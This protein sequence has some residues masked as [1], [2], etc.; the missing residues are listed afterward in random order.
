M[1]KRMA[2]Y[3]L[4]CKVNQ[5][6]TE[7]V[8]GLFQ[9]AGYVLVDFEEIAD[10]YLI[11]TCTVTSSA[12][13][14]SRQI[15]R[16]ARNLASARDGVVIVMGCYAQ[17]SAENL[18]EVLDVDLIV[19]NTHRPYL[20]EYFQRFLED[21]TPRAYVDDIMKE[22]EFEKVRIKPHAS[23]KKRTRGFLK[24]QEGCQQFCSYCIIPY[25]RGPVRSKPA[26]DVVEDIRN[27]VQEGYKEVVLT[28]IHTGSY[29]IDFSPPMPL[30]A[31]LSR[32]LQETTIPRIRISSLEPTEVDEELVTLMAENPRICN[33]L[34]I[35]LQSGDDHILK[36]MNRPYDTDYYRKKLAMIRRILPEIAITTDIITGFPGETETHVANTQTF[37]REMAF[38]GMHIFKYSPR[39]NTPASQFPEQVSG[40]EKEKRSQ[41]LFLLAEEMQREYQ[42]RFIGRELEILLEQQEG[43]YWEGHASNYLKVRVAGEGEKNQLR[44]VRVEK[45]EPNAM[46]GIFL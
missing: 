9:D 30:S 11:N 21:R 31:L 24:I 12:D 1:L 4:G 22:K 23:S 20:M 2:A 29:G 41:A 27:F 36:K 17:S 18:L 35:P 25:T 19:G 28:G 33:H 32:I 16:R 44:M 10:V 8:E 43:D 39:E 37:V 6:E 38:S 5:T 7:V 15:I 42:S 46:I 45:T 34:H 3:T 14:K 13:K 40:P 26:D